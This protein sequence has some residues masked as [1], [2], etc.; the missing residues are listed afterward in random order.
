MLKS[1]YVKNY[2]IISEIEIKFR[3]GFTTITG[4][5]GA[6]KSILVGALSMI[7]GNRADLSSLKKEDEKCVVEGTFNIKPYNLQAL[8]E[9]NDLEYEDITTIRRII[10]PSG[11]SRAFVNDLPVNLSFL[12]NLRAYLIDIHSQ[13]SNM[14]LNDIAFQLKLID[15]HAGNE[16]LLDKYK[17]KYREYRHV[18]KQYNDLKT[19]AEQSQADEEYYRFQLNQIRE[20]KLEENEQ[21]Q[22]EQELQTLNHSEEIK[23]N[24][25]RIFYAL[26][27][28]QENVLILLQDALQ[29]AESLKSYFNKASEIYERLHSSY[30]DL[31]DLTNEVEV[32]NNDVEYNP[33]RAQQI[34]ERLDNMYSLQQKHNV[35][36]VKELMELAQEFEAKLNRIDAYD[37]ELENLKN[38]IES[39]EKELDELASELIQSR[40]NSIPEVEKEVED[41]LS[42]LGIPNARFKVVHNILDYFTEYGKDSI[43]FNFT[44]NKNLELQPVAKVASGGE[45]S[46]I[47][48]AIK[49]LI[50]RSQALPSIIFDEIDSG[51]SGDIATRMGE[52]MK[53]MSAN[54]QVINITHLPQVAAKGDYHLS[55]YK[56]ENTEETSTGIKHLT[57][58]ERIHEIAKMLS[59]EN[60]TNAALDNAKVLLNQ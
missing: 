54:L 2:A 3:H 33:D 17:Q 24:L 43:Y 15:S 16:N 27:G 28:S 37:D 29:A 35:S 38:K 13:H 30:I 53:E 39:L 20:A 59:G 56:D 4:E 1:L 22:L 21:E 7:L 47:M 25:G 60:V 36:S 41:I 8:F 14:L 50:A 10:N 42:R 31:E 18:E 6:G 51:V 57:D 58:K 32:L 40:E 11:K 5:T 44:A 46:R 19:E 26:N 23:N 52:I 34:N 55:V 9:E 45:L 12:R 48:L 49:S